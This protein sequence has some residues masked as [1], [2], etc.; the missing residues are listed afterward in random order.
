MGTYWNGNGMQQTKLDAMK[1]AINHWHNEKEL[2]GHLSL[3]CTMAA[4]YDDFYNNLSANWG[5]SPQGH[6]ESLETV[7]NTAI[8]IQEISFRLDE[9]CLEQPCLCC[10][11]YDEAECPECEGYGTTMPQGLRDHDIEKLAPLFEA[12]TDMVYAWAWK[13]HTKEAIMAKRTQA[14]INLTTRKEISYR[15]LLNALRFEGYVSSGLTTRGSFP[16]RVNHSEMME[17]LQRIESGELMITVTA[18]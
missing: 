5:G 14:Q 7:P 10:G 15:Q 16:L 11:M 6:I 4:I 17:V 13:K 1:T 18:T 2:P 8:L 9:R 3:I 12:L